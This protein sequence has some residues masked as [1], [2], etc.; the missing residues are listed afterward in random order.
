MSANAYSMLTTVMIQLAGVPI[1]L[2]SWGTQLFGEWLVLSAI[3][4]Y[5][6]L[7]NL[8]YA[9]SIANDMTARIA[10]DDREGA[11]VAFHSLTALISVT[12]LAAVMAV[13]I[14]VTVV[15]VAGW[16]HLAGLSASMVRWVLILLVGE[17]LIQL[18]GGVSSA[19]YRA[20]GE[21]GLGLTL[22]ATVIL[23][24]YVAIW[25]AALS[26]FG[27]V[28][29]AVAFLSV[30]V[31]GTLMTTGILLRRHPWL[32][33]GFRQAR[34]RYI[35][36][37]LTPSLASLMLTI[38]NTLK[39]QGSLLVVNALLGPVA[40]VMFSV[41]RTLTRLSLRFVSIVSH[42][43]EP[44]VARAEGSRDHA[45]QRRL[46]LA[47]L[48]GSWW[49]SV[50]A[51]ISLYILGNAILRIWTHGEVPM[52]QTLFL[53]LLVASG[54]S[55]IWHVSLTMLQALNRHQRAAIAYVLCGIIVV[56]VAW[57]LVRTTG[58]VTGAGLALLIGDGLFVVYVLVAT[59]RAI[60]APLGAT[61]A[62]VVNPIALFRNQTLS[63][64]STRF[65]SAWHRV[66]R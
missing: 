14:I 54:I 66:F 60:Q 40:V 5:L 37:L 43:I 22:D 35:R 20:T 57:V 28:G 56:V 3:P 27:I 2:H 24:Q 53:W 6:S 25:S 19:G 33:L 13:T 51:G 45:L 49:L 1:L 64:I 50:L 47:G 30:R 17:V 10:R 7:A 26:G 41:L 12:T 46:Y 31:V 23:F 8:G 4:V 38:S 39:N 48:R 18:W 62:Y 55:A 61:L 9:L 65:M 42:S 52:D 34:L 44:E 16:L 36:R 21:Y 63:D 58:S 59:S 32:S 11:L 29:A 15:P